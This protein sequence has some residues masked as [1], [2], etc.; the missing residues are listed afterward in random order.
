MLSV[1]G[2][3]ECP[4]CDN[5]VIRY[6]LNFLQAPNLDVTEQWHAIHARHPKN[7][8]MVSQP[9]HGVRVV[10]ALG[11]SDMTLAFGL[12]RQVLGEMAI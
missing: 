8:Y 5:L 1:L 12:A 4:P 10:T 7:P 6:L 2:E 3:Q 11:D 9:T